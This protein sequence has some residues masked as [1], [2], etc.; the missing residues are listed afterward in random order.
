MRRLFLALLAGCSGGP[1]ECTVGSETFS[2]SLSQPNATGSIHIDAAGHATISGDNLTVR[3]DDGRM[4]T[5]SA[6]GIAARVPSGGAWN[7]NVF[8]EAASFTPQASLIFRTPG[9]ELKFAAWQVLV[10]SSVPDI[11]PLSTRYTDD[12]C[13]DTT[14]CGE[15]GTR[16]LAVTEGSTSISVPAGTSQLVSGL[17]VGNGNSKHITLPSSCTD[18][19]PMVQGY[20]ARD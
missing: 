7:I 1:G 20:V 14:A 3:F 19:A 13:E 2:L 8:F 18:I 15:S 4:V 11:A 5:G 6:P 10:T 17:R 12:A 16:T 9:G